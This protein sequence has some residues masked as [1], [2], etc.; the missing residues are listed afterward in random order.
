M[1]VL[2]GLIAVAVP[3]AVIGIGLEY[4]IYAGVVVAT[5][6]VGTFAQG[7]SVG[8]RKERGSA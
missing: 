1:N 3:M 6:T 4:G 8:V 5:T 2:D 7:L